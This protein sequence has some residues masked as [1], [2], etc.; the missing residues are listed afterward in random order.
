MPVHFKPDTFADAN[1]SHWDF[2]THQQNKTTDQ[3]HHNGYASLSNY[4]AYAAAITPAI[5]NSAGY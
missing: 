5:E 1:V 3:Y 2:P 4:A